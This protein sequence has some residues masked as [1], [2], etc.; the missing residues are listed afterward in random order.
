M[1]FVNV[2][3]APNTIQRT[4]T[5]SPTPTALTSSRRPSVGMARLELGD[6]YFSGPPHVGGGTGAQGDGEV[7]TT[8]LIRLS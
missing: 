7:P 8:G 3:G 4:L 2:S 5:Q 1:Y 6:L